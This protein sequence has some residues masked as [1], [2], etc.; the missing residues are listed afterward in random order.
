MT[1]LTETPTGMSLAA[2]LVR[3]C[4]ECGV[5]IEMLRAEQITREAR[6]AWPGDE[7]EQWS[8][9]LAESCESVHLR[10]RRVRL[11]A[12]EAVQL[13][14]DGA[15][16]AGGYTA[17]DGL[18]VVVGGGRNG[19]MIANGP[20]ESTRLAAS[21][22]PLGWGDES[23]GQGAPSAPEWV[24]VEHP[25]LTSVDSGED[26][27]H[28]P[29]AR[30]LKIV[31]PEWSDIWMLIVFALF[32]GVLNLA[33]PLAVESLVNTVAFGTLLQPVL[34]IALLL[35]GFLSFAALMK[36]MQTYVAEIIQRRLFAR[37]AADLAYRLPRV[38]THSLTHSYGPELVNRFLDV[39]TLQKVVANLLLD[40]V[41]I[42]LAT[43][44][45]MAVL[46]FYHPWLLGFD[47]LLMLVIGVGVLALGR[48]GIDSGID[49]SKHKYGLTAW[50]E[51]VIRCQNA[52]KADGGPSF[53]FDR[54]N[55]LTAKYLKSRQTH[56][57]ILFRQIL[58]IL[59]LQAVAGTVLLGVGGWLV[60]QQQLSLGQ[61]VAAELIVT[62]IL[63]S[64][65]KLGKHLEGFYDVVAAVDKLGYLFDLETEQPSGM[66]SELRTGRGL[67]VEML[68]VR[69][70][71][72]ECLASH[73]LSVSVEPGERVA[74]VGAAGSGKS[75]L[76]RI[77][78]GLEAP[79][80]GR[81]EIGG[82]DPTDL[83]HDIL[84]SAVGLVA[85]GEF[86]DGSVLENV[87]LGRPA[88]TT[89]HVR[90]ALEQVGLLESV[91]AL[92]D[93]VDHRLLPNGLPLSGNQQRLLMLARGIA[94]G[95][96]LLVIDG[97]LDPLP[98]EQLD[99][100]IAVLQSADRAWTVIVLTA[101]R[102]IAERFDRHFSLRKRQSA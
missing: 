30:L 88:V 80:A 75:T 37:V 17:A 81:V 52:F 15:K 102:S 38:E 16:L 51:D 66:T 79:T 3:L 31:R 11:S 59:T 36:A 12:G 49:E 45:G 100:A 57:R 29:V 41:S 34:I 2:V 71:T 70:A 25:E 82:C 35:F 95:H 101:K 14:A 64:L 89:S 60:I 7:A 23:N 69:A 20:F 54:A 43:L 93:G 63:A 47:L 46:A 67:P 86:F 19:L 94:G 62:T 6:E 74:V 24:V 5:D 91:L 1:K 84:R 68:S 9:W 10:A 83:R 73:G 58:F 13:A 26:L 90:S 48:G 96:E 22:E 28:R 85:E 21:D 87:R 72:G 92:P 50:F 55:Q 53:A 76:A 4:R 97:V 65:A 27:H 39:V 44:V 42:V 99:R 18:R 61:L 32:A 33:T 56:F 78:Y 77:L 98:D 8:T 40:G